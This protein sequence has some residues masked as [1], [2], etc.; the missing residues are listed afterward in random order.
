[1]P[2]E[3]ALGNGRLLINFDAE[4]NMRDLY[5]PY[6]GWPNHIGGERNR[7]GC[8]VDGHFSWLGS[9]EWERQVGYE[10]DTLV[11]HCRARHKDMEL[12]ININNAVHFQE[13]IYLARITVHNLAGRSREVRLFFYHDFTLNESPIGDTVTYLPD[14]KVLLHYKRGLY[15]LINGRAGA[16]IF[17]QYATGNKRFRGAEGTWRDAED[18]WLEGHPIHHGSVDSTFSFRLQLSAGE[19]GEIT[20]W[21]V[22]AENFTAAGE[23]NNWVLSQGVKNLLAAT[24]AYWRGW[25]YKNGRDFADL[26]PAVVDLYHRSLLVVRTQ[27]DNRGAILA[28]TDSDILAEARDHYGYCWPR[29]GALVASALDQAGYGELTASFFYYCSRVLEQDGFFYQKY[30]PDGSLGSSWLPPVHRG[31]RILPIQE[32][33]TAL[34]LWALGQSFRLG[35]NWGLIHDLYPALVRPAADFLV[36]YRYPDLGLPLPSY[37]LWEERRGIFTFTSAAVYAG[38]LAAADMARLAGDVGLEDRYRRAAVE[39]GVGISE[40]LYS[41]D[42]GRFIRGIYREDDGRLVP[43]FT[44][45][46]SLTAL[47]LLEA[48]P[49]ADPRLSR[50]MAAVE[51]GLQVKTEIGGVARYTGDYYF[52]KSDNLQV[53]PGNPWFICTLWL[54]EWHSLRAQNLNDLAAARAILTWAAERATPAGMLPEQLHPFT[55]EPLS[56]SPLT[57]SHATFVSAVEK[58]LARRRQLLA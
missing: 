20:Y 56:V 7:L 54:A 22:A 24:A 27:I 51:E 9:R 57:W 5:Y 11:G 42:L 52:R 29:D 35:R 18:G 14:Q 50:T 58:Y 41:P 16:N 55:G 21:I 25:V 36:D 53:A 3:L 13:D 15:L 19:R 48:V 10:A 28:A 2:R 46:A 8:W 43:D 30:N 33:E 12:E 4:F 34:V 49:L 6:V 17:F 32:D 31:E 45:D 44:L 38:L 26:P 1:M 23:L 40:H 47:A 37:D 39:V